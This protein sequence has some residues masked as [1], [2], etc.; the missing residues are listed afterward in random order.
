MGKSMKAK[1]LDAALNQL[2]GGSYDIALILDADNLMSL[3]VSK[4]STRP[5]KPEEKPQCHR[6][7]K[8]KTIPSRYLTG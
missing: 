5:S 3:D 7:A 1:S 8:T 2:S 4:I 6:T